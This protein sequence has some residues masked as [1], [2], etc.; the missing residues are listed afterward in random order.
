MKKLM[1]LFVAFAFVGF[2][3]A[4]TLNDDPPVKK[5]ETTQ[6]EKKDA[7]APGCETKKDCQTVKTTCCSK[8]TQPAPAEQKK[9]KK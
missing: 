9:D 7:K 4:N 5:T 3:S 6:V 1:L 8:K 2:L